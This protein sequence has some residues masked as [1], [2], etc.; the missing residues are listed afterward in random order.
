MTRRLKLAGPDHCSKGCRATAW[1]ACSGRPREALQKRCGASCDPER[2]ASWYDYV[3]AQWGECGRVALEDGEILGFVKYAPSRVTSRR[4]STSG[5]APVREGR[6]ARVP[7]HR[8][9]TRGTRPRQ[10]A[11]ARGSAR[12]G[13][14][15]GALR[16]GVR[17]R[18]AG[19]TW[20]RCPWWAWSSCS[21]NGFTVVRPTPEYPLLRLD[22]RSL[23]TVDRERRGRTRGAAHP[24]GRHPQPAYRRRPS[25]RKADRE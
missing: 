24:A 21:R 3:R 13:V 11:A 19:A 1:D 23:A 22:L 20:T 7:A 17:V 10:L 9:T 5:R 4:R 6:A 8:A 18:P 15:R 14:A 12:P 16:G 25:K 2:L